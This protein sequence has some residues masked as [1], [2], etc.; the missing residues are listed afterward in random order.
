LSKNEEMLLTY[1]FKLIGKPFEYGGRGPSGFDCFGLT[2]EFFKRLGQEVRDFNNPEFTRKDIHNTIKY[3]EPLLNIEKI[4]NPEPYCFVI[5]EIRPPFI[6]HI[7][8]VLED[9]NHFLH[10]RPKISTCIEK[11]DKY[12]WKKRIRGFYR[13]KKQ[14]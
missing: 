1:P 14:D 13:W 6:S 11:L 2:I 12:E 10:V 3:G 9:C 7:G 8:V 4:D 5:F